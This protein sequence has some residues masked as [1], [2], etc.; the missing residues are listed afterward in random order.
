MSSGCALSVELMMWLEE[1]LQASKSC[2][3]CVSRG[4]GHGCWGRR[5][6]KL[7]ELEELG[8]RAGCH[9]AIQRLHGGCRVQRSQR[10]GESQGQCGLSA[11]QHAWAGSEACGADLADADRAL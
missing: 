1:L 11:V 7:R 9:V 2:K 8:L 5:P 6:N 3:S 10:Q 4:F